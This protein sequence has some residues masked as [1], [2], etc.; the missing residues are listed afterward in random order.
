MKFILRGALPVVAAILTTLVIM[1]VFTLLSTGARVPVGGHRMDPFAPTEGNRPARQ[2]PT[3]YPLPPV[4]LDQDHLIIQQNP[5]C[6]SGM[7]GWTC[8]KEAS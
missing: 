4:H 1:T 6:W 7:P 8:D 3:G 5:T 2:G